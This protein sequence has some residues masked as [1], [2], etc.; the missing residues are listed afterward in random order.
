[1]KA[2]RQAL[3]GLWPS[4]VLGLWPQAH[5]EQPASRGAMLYATQCAACHTTQ[6]HWR[7]RRLATDWQS[8]QAQVRRW[9]DVAALRW[10]EE[11]VVEVTRHLNDTF[12]NF[13]PPG[14][15][16][17]AIRTGAEAAALRPGAGAS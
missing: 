7:A 12:Y 2:T 11:D 8:L 9:Q 5:A 15:R 17:G 16:L 1:M 13:E 4:L 10:T 6:V 14:G 3:L